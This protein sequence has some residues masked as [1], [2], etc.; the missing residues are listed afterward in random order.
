MCDYDMFTYLRFVGHQWRR[1]TDLYSLIDF[2]CYMASQ[3]LQFSFEDES[4]YLE[5]H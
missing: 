2:Y 5:E 4:Q 3:A 1:D